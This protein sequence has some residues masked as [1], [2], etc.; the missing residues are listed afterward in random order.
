VVVD[1]GENNDKVEKK[2]EG[3]KKKELVQIPIFPLPASFLFPGIYVPLHIFE[4][5]YKAMLKKVEEMDGDLAISY[6]P[7]IQPGKFFP[8]MICG[9]GPVRLLRRNEKSESDIL[10]FGTHR[11]KFHRY[12]QE[13]PYLIGE[14]E[15]LSI[16]R[17]M[18]KKTEE[19]LTNQIRDMMVSWVFVNFEDS[20]RPLQF[21]KNI[22]DLEVLANF[23]A[24][25]FVTDPEKKQKLLEE[26][27]LEVKAQ[28][29][30]QILKDLED[31]GEKGPAGE[32]LLFP[33]S[34]SEDPLN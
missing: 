19:D 10:V 20:A 14:G 30:W 16:H 5:R 21:F 29:V 8:H 27:N 11:V 1:D 31:S 17:D 13:I 32:L 12:I 26:D 2:V 18:P 25:Y 4:E 22:S 3:V 6:A 33:G 7:E 15:V 24:Y 28:A 34:K 23:V 9:A